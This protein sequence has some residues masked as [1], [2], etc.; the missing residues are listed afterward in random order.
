MK[1]L[2]KHKSKLHKGFIKQVNRQNAKPSD[3]KIKL[4]ITV[5][6]PK[7]FKGKYKHSIT[8]MNSKWNGMNL[9]E[10]C[11]RFTIIRVGGM[12]S[13]FSINKH[14]KYILSMHGKN[15]LRK[16]KLKIDLK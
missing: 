12:H 2:D 8:V 11:N 9:I 14:G 1:M 15:I 13:K 3:V 10:L 7:N 6:L 5:K 4:P 16:K